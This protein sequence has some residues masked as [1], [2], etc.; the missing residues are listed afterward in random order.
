M[1]RWKGPG[2]QWNLASSIFV[3]PKSSAKFLIPSYSAGCR[4]VPGMCVGGMPSQPGLSRAGT[5]D[6]GGFKF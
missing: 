6:F 1:D 3:D 4:M 2:L 5:P